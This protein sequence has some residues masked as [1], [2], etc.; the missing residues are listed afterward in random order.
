VYGNYGWWMPRE[1]SPKAMENALKSIELDP[2]V[3]ESHASLAAVRGTYEYDWGGGEAELRR[4]IELNPS[5]AI[6]H[7]WYSLQL[8]YQGRLEQSYEEIR[9]ASLLDPH[10]R[11]IHANLGWVLASLGRLKEAIEH[12]ERLVESEPAYPLAHYDLAWMLY[13]DSRVGDAVSEM[14]SA[15]ALAGDG[16][17][18]K[19][20]L[21]CLLG[22]AGERDEADEIVAQMKKMSETRYVSKG[23]IAGALF[24]LGRVDEA[25]RYLQGAYED[26]SEAVLIF[27]QVQWFAKWRED[28][29]WISIDGRLGFGASG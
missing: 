26:R 1:A 13:L 27:R 28:P 25:F 5:Y 11:I 2:S 6:A 22:L 14:R 24:G 4:A 7:Q 8:W 23:G 17:Q 20:D 18:F 12:I 19:G 29:R 15:V 10:S 9:A 16:L 3:A 21:A